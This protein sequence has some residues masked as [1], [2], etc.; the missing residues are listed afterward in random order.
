MVYMLTIGYQKLILQSDTGIQTVLK[1][2]SKS[3]RVEDDYRYKDEGISLDSKPV[4]VSM[5]VLHDFKIVTRARRAQ[6]TVIEPEVLPPHV[7]AID[8]ARNR[9]LTMGKLTREG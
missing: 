7:N 9:Q 6:A 2:L 1:C 3:I 8:R 5:E 4:Q